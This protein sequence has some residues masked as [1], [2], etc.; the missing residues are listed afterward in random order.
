MSD[1]MHLI[2]ELDR[3][4]LR[5][6]GLTTGLIVA[7]LFGIFFPWLF[8]AGFVRWPWILC[9]LLI[10]MGLLTPMALGPVYH[11]WMRFG[12]MMSRF[13]SPLIMGLVF[14]LVITP[15]AIFMKLLGKDAMRRKLAKDESTY[16]IESIKT[17][18][19]RIERPY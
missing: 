1:T 9:G 5:K 12:L 10:V 19:E 4:G 16:R 18:R 17:A 14:F 7:G 6:F 8:E 3:Q 2:P 13:T 15:V 11:W